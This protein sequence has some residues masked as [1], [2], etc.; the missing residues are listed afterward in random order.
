MRTI[1]LTQTVAA[2]PQDIYVFFVPQRMP[3]WYGPEMQSSFETQ[4]CGS[5]F[6]AGSRV[7]ISGKL[8]NRT[9]SHTAVVTAFD[10]PRRFEWRFEDEYGVRGTERWELE[11]A[12]DSSHA[13]TRV[14]FTN[15]YEIAGRFARIVDWLLTRHALKRRNR[16]YLNRLARL[17]ERRP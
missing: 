4:G 10:K 17:A 11:P 14:R 1:V 9:F 5:E 15:E 13:G 2:P 6:R 8:A 3:Y 7:R 16:D 12:G